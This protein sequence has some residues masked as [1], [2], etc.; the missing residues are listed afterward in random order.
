[1]TGFPIVTASYF[2]QMSHHR[3]PHQ[4]RRLC[5]KHLYGSIGVRQPG[6]DTVMA[7]QHRHPVMD[8][9][10]SL[11]WRRSENGVA[12]LPFEYLPQSRQIYHR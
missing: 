12:A 11:V 2:E 9:P 7:E 3:F 6:P 4:L 10:H 8:G 1:M 5:S